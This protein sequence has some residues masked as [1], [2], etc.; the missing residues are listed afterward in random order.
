MDDPFKVLYIHIPF[1][2][3]RC[4]YC[5]F[6]TEAVDRDDPVIRDYVENLVLS[7][8]RA[9][10]EGILG[11]LETVYLG[12]GTP[13]YLGQTYLSNILY[14]LSTSMHLT[15]EVECSMEANPE[16]ITEALIRDIWALG[17]N[18]LSIGVQS[19]DD[20]VLSTLGRAHTADDARKA[21]QTAQTRLENISI[22]L[23]CGIP[24][25]SFDD[26]QAS[27]EEALKLG[28]K[29]VSVYPLTIEEDTAL[30]RMILAGELDE[31]DQD[32]QAFMMQMAASILEPQGLHRYEVANY[33]V[34]GFEC[35]HNTAY[36]TGKPYLGL[37]T[38]AVTM[39]QDESHRERLQDGMV[40]ETLDRR[41]MAAEDLMLAMRMTEGVAEDRVA[42][43]SVL[44]P[45]T[46]RTFRE[47]MSAGL[48]EKSGG[49]YRPTLAGWLCGNELY[50]KLL[51]LAP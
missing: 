32:S 37:G 42:E 25:Q 19:F 8:R 13:S 10:K 36:W 9:S 3:E 48:V 24:G 30:D 11:Q 22:D 20:T 47:L 23:M 16:S 2:K 29:H 33:A 26:F 17:V 6:V 4:N 14:T 15:S 45:E 34:P 49:R 44:L 50:A 5:D 7:I 18:R 43:V 51:A 27:L 1:C 35:R 41:Q 39:K 31:I 46:I 21:I 40:C 38:S 12:G 28:V